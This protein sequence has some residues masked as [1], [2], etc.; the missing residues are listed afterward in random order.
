MGQRICYYK[1]N[2]GKGL[3]DLIVENFSIFRQWHLDRAK[4]SMEEF[5]EPFGDETLDSYLRQEDILNFD[6]NKLDKQ[7][8]DELTA[9]FIDYWNTIDGDGK[10]L[11]FF[12]P[13]VSK[14][15]YDGS[16]EM[17]LRTDEK[18]FI[19]L[20][21]FLIKGRSLKDNADFKSYSNE[22]KIGFLAFDENR[23]LLTKI[24]LHFGNLEQIKHN[25]WTDEDK[26]EEQKAIQNSR[27]K[28]YLSSGHNSNAL[29]LEYVLDIL[30]QITPYK[31]ELI[32]AIDNS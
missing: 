29:G 4:S 3:K 24:E 26:L 25:Y 5:N 18:D 10:I 21:N 14:N 16:T 31:N 1:N 15:Q 28:T 8:I 20:W 2:S 30:N 13:T 19:Q 12:G 32:T 6:L 7:L 22:D 11:E 9:K 23:L 17:V 27:N